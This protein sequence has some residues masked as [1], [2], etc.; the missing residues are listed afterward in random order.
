MERSR[1]K[2]QPEWVAT[3]LASAEARLLSYATSIVK[4]RERARDVVQDAVFLKYQK[5]IKRSKPAALA[6]LF[7]TCRNRAIDLLRKEDRMD[8]SGQ[9]EVES[10]AS[11]APTPSTEM[12]R[13]EAQSELH[14]VLVVLSDNQ[15][16]V[17]R[18]RFQGG[19][20]YRQIA[21]VTELSVS[22]VGVLIHEA[23]RNLRGRLTPDLAS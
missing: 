12:E 9:T 20:S 3:L 16:E 7:R 15:R 19:L 21:E 10:A 2:A 4:D 22:N 14:R 11:A 17:L 18:L 5:M 13:R 8:P 23:L 6:W 1:P